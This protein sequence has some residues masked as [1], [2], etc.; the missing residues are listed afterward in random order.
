MKYRRKLIALGIAILFT[1]AFRGWNT[2]QAQQN[3]TPTTYTS[4]QQGVT[5]SSPHPGWLQTSWKSLWTQIEFKAQTDTTQ[6]LQLADS[7]AQFYQ[8]YSQKFR[9]RSSL[10][11]SFYQASPGDLLHPE[12]LEMEILKYALYAHEVT[13]GAIHPGIANLIKHYGLEYGQQP[14]VPSDSLLQSERQVLKS[15]PFRVLNDSTIEVLQAQRHLAFGAYSKGYA[16]EW[17]RQLLLRHQINNFWLEIGGDLVRE[18]HSIEG[19]PWRAGVQDPFAERGLHGILEFPIQSPMKSLATSGNYQQFFRDSQG[20]KHHHILDPRTAQSAQ[21]KASVSVLAQDGL[22]A[23]LWATAFFIL[24]F[25]E[26]QAILNSRPE[27]EAYIIFADSTIWQ[28]PGFDRF[29]ALQTLPR[30]S[31][32]SLSTSKD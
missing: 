25:S 24:D 30:A 12:A 4:T 23:D 13:Q 6:F 14:Q 16:L 10:D 20:R 7:I 11:S 26:I 19:R 22:S 27:L 21:G 8:G 17:A 1:L 29:Q 3:K 32:S 28:S 2:Y 5:V 9:S 15:L 31:A 18:G